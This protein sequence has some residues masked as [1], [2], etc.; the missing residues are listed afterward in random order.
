M[1]SKIND[2]MSDSSSS[3]S[4][5]DDEM[6]V[7]KE[8]RMMMPINSKKRKNEYEQMKQKKQQKE[9]KNKDPLKLTTDN[10]CIFFWGNPKKELHLNEDELRNVNIEEFLQY[11]QNKDPSLS[12]EQQ[13]CITR[14]ICSGTFEGSFRSIDLYKRYMSEEYP[15][16]P[17]YNKPLKLNL[18]NYTS[19]ETKASK[20]A[21]TSINVFQIGKKYPIMISSLTQDEIDQRET[22]QMYLVASDGQYVQA[23]IKPIKLT[24]K[25]SESMV[26]LDS[27][28]I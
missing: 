14:I 23:N 2:E 21:H 26:L 19:I 9:K 17:H 7:D 18:L 3:D 27:K 5:S 24:M 16:V 25:K 12:L 1:R 6:A 11:I 20:D 15:D 28:L 10:H 4:S 13:Q 8:A 22:V